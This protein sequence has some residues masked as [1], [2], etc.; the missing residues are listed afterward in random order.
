MIRVTLPAILCNVIIRI[1]S[2]FSSYLQI[3]FV[4][5]H[6]LNECGYV[7]GFPKKN[8]VESRTL[9]VGGGNVDDAMN[10]VERS[11]ERKG[12]KQCK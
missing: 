5:L 9:S 10:N 4:L 8:V 3:S 11:N 1:W 6:R 12:G 2:V 7:S